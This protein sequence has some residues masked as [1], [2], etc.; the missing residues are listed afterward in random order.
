MSHMETPSTEM[1]NITN[2]V[3][4]GEVDHVDLLAAMDEKIARAKEEAASRKGIIEKVDRWMLASDEERW[5]E[6]YD[7]VPISFL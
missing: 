1:G 6:E 7:Q 4:S 5:L 3:D 2:L